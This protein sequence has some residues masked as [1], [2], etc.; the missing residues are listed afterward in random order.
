M[1]GV[2]KWFSLVLL[3][4][5]VVYKIFTL[6]QVAIMVKKDMLHMG[7]QKPHLRIEQER[8]ISKVVNIM[9]LISKLFIYK[10]DE[11]TDYKSGKFY[12]GTRINNIKKFFR[13]PKSL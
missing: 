1:A 9:T 10:H 11:S 7:D 2:F 5:S 4:A 6:I 13:N 8:I 3:H 12:R